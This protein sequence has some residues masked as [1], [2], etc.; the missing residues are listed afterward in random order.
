MNTRAEHHTNAG[1]PVGA[2]MYS[3][4]FF[5]KR[6][7]AKKCH[8]V[9][10]KQVFRRKLTGKGGALSRFKYCK[11]LTQC[12]AALCQPLCQAAGQGAAVSRCFPLCG[13]LFEALAQKKHQKSCMMCF[14][15]SHVP[16]PTYAVKCQGCPSGPA[17]R[18]DS[19]PQGALGCDNEL[20]IIFML[21]DTAGAPRAAL[22]GWA[23]GAGGQL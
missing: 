8:K 22:R 15:T 14:H 19:Y 9:L 10:F 5:L 17:A 4:D 21:S 18:R 23:A 13:F 3:Q 20:M 2:C 7:S 1:K 16:L 6:Q 11:C 12:F